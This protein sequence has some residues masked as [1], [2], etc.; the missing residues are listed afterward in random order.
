MVDNSHSCA[1]L[2]VELSLVICAQA[3]AAA[4]QNNWQEDIVDVSDQ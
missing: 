4:A 1:S 3:A 2:G